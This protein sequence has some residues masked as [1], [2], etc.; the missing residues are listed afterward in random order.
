[1]AAQPLRIRDLG[2]SPGVLP[3]GPTN[4]I[5]DIPGV[6]V[7]QVTVPTSDDLS[8][9][10]TATKGLTVISARP[11]R[12][13]YKPCHA[14]TFT[15]NGNGELTCSRQIADWGYI[16]TPI[17]FTNSLSL[18]TVFDGMVRSQ[19]DMSSNRDR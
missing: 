6:H 14:S 8:H 17:A 15:L 19:K 3:T 10:L 13:F 5:L 7:S 1:M 11:P 2:Y 12:E 4:S 16:N 18:G 9:G